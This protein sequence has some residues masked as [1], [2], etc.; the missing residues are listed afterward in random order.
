MFGAF[1][2]FGGT[3]NQS[4]L[5]IITWKHFSTYKYGW[6]LYVSNFLL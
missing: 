3:K 2:S 1:A 5:T 4:K 6:I